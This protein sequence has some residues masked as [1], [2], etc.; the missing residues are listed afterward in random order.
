M[1]RSTWWMIGGL[2]SL[3]G[4]VLALLN[5]FAGSLAAV[6]LAGWAFLILG[7]LQIIAVFTAHGAGSKI[8]FGLLGLVSTYLGI[9]LFSNP[10]AGV[11]T[12]ALAVALLLIIS[13]VTRLIASFE[14]RGT[15]AFW[16]LLLSSAISIL[17]G[18]MILSDYPMSA[19]SI[20]GILL[21]V[22][23]IFSGISL[24][25]LSGFAKRVEGAVGGR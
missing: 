25:S 7:L 22:E 17:L 13:G 23:L 3:I 11:L 1:K 24:I 21:G 15:T 20:L 5:P 14:F 16:L 19:M 18:C 2:L 9:S 8:W 6:A 10:L 12:L 4:G